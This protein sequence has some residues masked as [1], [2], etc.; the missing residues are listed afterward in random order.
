MLQDLLS[1]PPQ[2]T[3]RECT[4]W[5]GYLYSR[6][7]GEAQKQKNERVRETR[8]SGSDMLAWDSSLRAAAEESDLFSGKTKKIQKDSKAAQVRG[9]V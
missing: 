4:Q 8:E 2:L 3:F 5:A 1:E 7:L 6:K 9:S